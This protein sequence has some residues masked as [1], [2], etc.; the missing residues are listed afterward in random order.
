MTWRENAVALFGEDFQSSLAVV[1]GVAVRTAQRWAVADHVPAGVEAWLARTV[2][3]VPEVLHRAYG[4]G[5]AA[6]LRRATT[7]EHAVATSWAIYTTM[8]RSDLPRRK[9]TI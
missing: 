7:E 1:A 5:L 3:A 6:V 9:E 2:E 8:V 4:T